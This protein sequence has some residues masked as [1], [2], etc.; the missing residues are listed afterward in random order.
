MARHIRVEYPGA[1]YRVTCRMMG[2]WWPEKSLLFRD[3]ADR[4]RF[5]ERLG[6][7]VEQFHIRLF[8]F[9]CMTNHFLLVFE[10]PEANCSKFMQ[11]AGR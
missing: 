3:E 5:I 8:S 4:E 11:P 7:R 9:V 6:E 10:T 1:I 2:D